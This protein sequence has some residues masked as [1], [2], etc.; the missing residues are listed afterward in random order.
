VEAGRLERH[1][2][3]EGKPADEHGDGDV[4]EQHGGK[5]DGC[6]TS[7]EHRERDEAHV[8]VEVQSAET[9][10]WTGALVKDAGAAISPPAFTPCYPC[11]DMCRVT[12]APDNVRESEV[13]DAG[14]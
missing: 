11:L 4:H 14:A 9:I 2:V 8:V 3:D 13:T 12:S 5:N 10:E 6:P 1:D 7:R